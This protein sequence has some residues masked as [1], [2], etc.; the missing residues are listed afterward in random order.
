LLPFAVTSRGARRGSQADRLAFAGL[1]AAGAF[2]SLLVLTLARD[3]VLVVASLVPV[4]WLASESFDALR[5]ASAAAVP[6]LA[7]ALTLLGFWNAR[8]VPRVRRVDVPIENLPA[9]LHGFSIVQVTDLHVGAT[10]R[11]RRSRRS[12]IA[13]TRSNADL[14]A[15]TGDF[16]DGSVR[17]L[18]AHTQPLGRSPRGTARTS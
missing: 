4:A 1:V 5:S 12:S 17:E 13:S 11:R 14:I 16:V 15:L 6:A 8:R 3:L 2:S 10:I 9:A 18:G 7:A